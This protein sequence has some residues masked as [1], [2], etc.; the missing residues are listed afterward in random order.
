MF[1]RRQNLIKFISKQLHLNV[2]KFRYHAC[3]GNGIIE[4][5]FKVCSVHINATIFDLLIQT[6]QEAVAYDNRG[7]VR[8]LLDKGFVKVTFSDRYNWM[9]ALLGWT[10]RQQLTTRCH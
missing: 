5:F 1:A 9:F 2:S 6:T 10:P 7:V 4:T 3:L 8:H